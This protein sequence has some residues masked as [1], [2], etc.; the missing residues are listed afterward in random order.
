M[1]PK[2]QD[3]ITV[4]KRDLGPMLNRF[5]KNKLFLA[6]LI[7]YIGLQC[8]ILSVTI[9][10]ITNVIRKN[11]VQFSSGFPPDCNEFA[12]ETCV[13][14][15]LELDS[16]RGQRYKEPIVFNSTR[17]EIGYLLAACV[18]NA[19]AGYDYAATAINPIYESCFF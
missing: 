18:E 5:R 12:F 1:V 4:F 6:A 3:K 16:C 19:T 10:R 17:G 2:N 15:D 9:Q 7:F 14:V 11:D 8:F 13:R